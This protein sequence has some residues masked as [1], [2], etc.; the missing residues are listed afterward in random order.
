MKPWYMFAA[1]TALALALSGCARDRVDGTAVRPAPLSH[2]LV[3]DS[4]LHLDA[5]APVGTVAAIAGPPGVR[6][7]VALIGVSSSALGLRARCD[8]P[9]RFRL[10]PDP[11]EPGLPAA[12]PAWAP[13]GVW[14][15]ADLPARNRGGVTLDL[16][17][18]TLGCD[19]DVR[20]A[21]GAPYTLSL[22]REGLVRPALV[23]LDPTGAGGAATPTCGP[24]SARDPLV[25]AFLAPRALSMTCPIPVGPHRL[26]PDELAAFDAKVEALTG[27]RLGAAAL[28]SGDPD[29]P[30]DFS[31]APDLDLIVVSYLNFNADFTG[32]LMARMLAHHAAR[33][34][35]VRILVA[36]PMWLAADRALFE[37]LAARHPTIQLYPFRYAAQ[38]GDGFE[39][40]A[41]AIHR[42]QHVKLFATLARQP[43]RSRAMIGGRNLADGYVFATPFDL[44]A[45]PN[46]RQYARG[47][48]L[49][50]GGFHSYRDLEIEFSGQDQV[51]AIVAHWSGL[52]HGSGLR[53]LPGGG[54]V[55]PIA[56]GGA[57][58]RH[59]L[60]VPW[61][62]GQAQVG[63]YADLID[64]AQERIDIASPYLNPPQGVAAAL[65]RAIARGV[66]V[67][68][69]TTERVREP[70]DMFITG[71]NRMFG[72]LYARRLSYL[73]H[74]PYPRLLHTKAMVIDGRLVVLGSTNLNQ[75]SFVHD[76]E[77]GVIV[78]D[79]ELARRVR[80]L[81]DGYA[82]D[83]RPIAPDARVA[84]LV[85]MLLLWP[86]LR[87]A[88]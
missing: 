61:A 5:R 65:D 9:A 55:A 18:G 27:R 87:R 85:R 28:S 53:V 17:P 84:P 31:A 12:D 59:Y 51:R 75:R 32:A 50:S 38:R 72:A 58:M 37:G 2:P 70:G 20:P 45:R 56:T 8:G 3:A 48:G 76:L 63:L 78:L 41:G 83:A 6:A 16:A 22:T 30:L 69:V 21:R 67:R 49:L 29:L 35:I 81:I 80:S 68:I 60:S 40:H 19:L 24:T 47:R 11:P 34:T 77:N 46:L 86:A 4:R 23:A 42:V 64:A 82:T 54:A 39:D 74:D 57:R 79:T 73:D 10:R 52:W 7:Q 25:A 44:S 26:L 14:L 13:E 33:G 66:Q 1:A 43:G 62:D 71:L 15:A 36:D 88:F